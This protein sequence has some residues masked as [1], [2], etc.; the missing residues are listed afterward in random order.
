MATTAKRSIS[1]D[2]DFWVTTASGIEKYEN[3]NL[4]FDI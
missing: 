4:S 3:I 2:F 1:E